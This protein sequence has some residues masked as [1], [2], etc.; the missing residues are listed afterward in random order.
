[1]IDLSAVTFIDSSALG[2]LIGTHKRSTHPLK[3]VVTPDRQVVRV[4]E[5]TG[6]DRVLELHLSQD[7]ALDL[8]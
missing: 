2:V 5:K 1:M 6:L 8:N 3:V 4:I 7:E